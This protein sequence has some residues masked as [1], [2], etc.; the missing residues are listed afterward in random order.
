MEYVE[1]GGARIPK[2]G[3]GTWQNTGPG[4]ADTVRT[5]LERGYRHVDTAQVYDNERFVGEGI[6]AAEVDRDAVFLTT[7]VWRSNLRGG[8]VRS[9]V[10]ESLE[11][12][13]VGYVDLL[14]IH[15]PHPRVPIE[16]TLN[17][18]VALRQEGAVRHLGVS[19][20]TRSQL[21]KATGVVD[22]PIVTDQVLYHPYKQ[23]DGLREFCVG[24]DVA[25]TAYS[26]LGR[27]DV[28]GDDT[29]VEIGARYDKTAPQVAL[30]WLIQQD[31][32][33]AIPKATSRE[34]L[35]ENLAVF[36]FSLSPEEMAAIHD[37]SPGLRRRLR[38]YIP[39]LVRRVPV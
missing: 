23:Q 26:P 19:N 31:A 18:M 5:A 27:G 7:K 28:L 6:A 30:R 12:L 38:N 11:K 35:A 17:A 32:V 37:R 4:C 2:L 10:R 25:L 33:V 24:N 14:L 39:R 36:D 15:W 9:T 3:V 20:F 13:G 22:A 34:H 21:R 29:L 1:A 16:E 8:D